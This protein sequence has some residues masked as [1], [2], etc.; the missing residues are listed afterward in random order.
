MV[1]QAI[2]NASLNTY[3]GLDLNAATGLATTNGG[4]KD[5]RIPFTL[6]STYR[7]Q[8]SVG[9]AN[10]SGAAT[11]KQD[12]RKALLAQEL[13]QINIRQ[14]LNTKVFSNGQ[15]QAIPFTGDTI[16]SMAVNPSS[17]KWNQPKRWVKRDTM[18]GSVFFH[19]TDRGGHN[20]DVL[21]LSFSG[22]TGN[23]NAYNTSIDTSVVTGARIKLKMFHDLYN[24]TREPVLLTNGQRNDVFITYQTLIMPVPVTFIGFFNTVLEFSESS[25]QPFSRDYSFSFTVLGSSPSLND[26]SSKV[27]SSLLANSFSSILQTISKTTALGK[28]LA[29]AS[30]HPAPAKIPG[31]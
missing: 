3:T 23:I 14:Q 18:G 22:N 27:N 28:T 2:I 25:S 10:T 9:V 13:E 31:L 26:I 17:V 24:L 11:T 16:I 6:T 30:G 19:F 21:T 8:N 7:L 12:Q 5:R 29:A 1:D 15:A 4:G 20:N